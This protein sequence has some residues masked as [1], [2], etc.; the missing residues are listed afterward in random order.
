MTNY[1]VEVVSGLEEGKRG[2][3]GVG[4]DATWTEE[5]FGTPTVRGNDIRVRIERRS[6]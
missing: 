3:D 2:I 6:V 4:A 5:N 1:D